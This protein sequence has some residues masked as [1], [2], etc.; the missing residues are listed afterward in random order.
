LLGMSHRLHAFGF[1]ALLIECSRAIRGGGMLTRGHG[2]R[3]ALGGLAH[4]RCRWMLDGR[5]GCPLLRCRWLARGLAA[6]VFGRR[7]LTLSRLAHGGGR[8]VLV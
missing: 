1:V 6:D 3:L 7:C 2:S 8:R 4:G 5:T